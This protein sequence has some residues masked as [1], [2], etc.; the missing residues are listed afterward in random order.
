MEIQ[1]PEYNQLFTLAKPISRNAR[2]ALLV[3]FYPVNSS[4]LDLTSYK[5]DIASALLPILTSELHRVQSY[6]NAALHR[7][8]DLKVRE[9][10]G[11]LCARYFVIKSVIMLPIRWM[12][13]VYSRDELPLFTMWK[14]P[15]LAMYQRTW[16]I[17][18][19]CIFT[20]ELTTDAQNAIC[21]RACVATCHSG[22]HHTKYHFIPYSRFTEAE[23]LNTI[24]DM[25]SLLRQSPLGLPFWT[26]Q[27]S[28]YEVENA[29][30]TSHILTIPEGK[31]KSN[32][33]RYFL[34]KRMPLVITELNSKF[35]LAWSPSQ[36]I[37]DYGEEECKVEDCEGI[38]TSPQMLLKD[39]L[40]C[41]SDN[42]VHCSSAPVWKVKVCGK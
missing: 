6:S 31:L 42:D 34:K 2:L 22:N 7:R 5:H 21:V 40:R 23:L 33:F 14:R 12:S 28:K 4:V 32:E 13:Y 29:E 24:D 10:C 11:M 16:G 35:Q 25:T 41:F 3:G 20:K 27:Y 19:S 30:Q 39:F 36:L 8:R 1:K 15:L 17:V 26:Y 37:C 9:V 38:T 18:I